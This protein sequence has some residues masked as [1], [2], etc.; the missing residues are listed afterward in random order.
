MN[1]NISYNEFVSVNNVLNE[2][3]DIKEKIRDSNNK[4]NQ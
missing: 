2:H 1:S 3:D 4:R